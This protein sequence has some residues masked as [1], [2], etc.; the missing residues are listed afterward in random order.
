MV[1]ERLIKSYKKKP[2]VFVS[3]YRRI[4]RRRMEQFCVE[5]NEK[6][7]EKVRRGH[8]LVPGDRVQSNISSYDLYRA[9]PLG[10]A[11]AQQKVFHEGPKKAT[12][13]QT[14]KRLSEMDG[15]ASII[16]LL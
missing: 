11:A 13:L 15:P 8:S 12:R 16:S 4:D 1:F 14:I 6:L 7:R 5:E 9:T 2:C 3:A 10:E